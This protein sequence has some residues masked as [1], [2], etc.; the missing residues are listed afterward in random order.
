MSQKIAEP[1]VY[2]IEDNHKSL[3]KFAQELRQ[4]ASADEGGDYS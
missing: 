4:P 3:I 2:K 1:I